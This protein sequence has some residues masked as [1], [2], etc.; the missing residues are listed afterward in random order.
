MTT[1]AELLKQKEVLEAHIDKARKA[2]VAEA[3]SQVRLL[4]E[5]YQ[6]SQ[7][8]V[9]GGEKHRR[10]TGKRG[11]VAPKYRDPQ[12]GATWSGR[13]KAPSWIAG[14]DRRSFLV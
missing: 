6:L 7:Q 10:T 5:Q 1:L 12:S 4:I 3:I 2:E 13:G 14:K 11:T 8:D 9:F